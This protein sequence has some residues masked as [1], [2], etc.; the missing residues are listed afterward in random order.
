MIIKFTII[1]LKGVIWLFYSEDITSVF[2]NLTDNEL[3]KKMNM[4][5][6]RGK[7]RNIQKALDSIQIVKSQPDKVKVITE[8]CEIYSR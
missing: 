7:R 5:N 4:N 6:I 1:L 2:R 8:N 3:F